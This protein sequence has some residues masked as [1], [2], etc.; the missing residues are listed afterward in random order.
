MPVILA[1]WEAEIGRIAVKGHPEQIV[2]KTGGVA[3]VGEPLFYKH[4][5]L[6]SNPS[7]TKI[8]K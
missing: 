4:E 2:R 7:P 1:L 8:N 5:T 6:N 3:Q